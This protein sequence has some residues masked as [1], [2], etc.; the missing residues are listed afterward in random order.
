MSEDPHWVARTLAEF[1]SV[2]S[3]VYEAPERGFRPIDLDVPVFDDCSFT[4]LKKRRPLMPRLIA[5]GAS[6]SLILGLLGA[7][8]ASGQRAA[9]AAEWKPDAKAV[10]QLGPSVK[11]DSYTIRIPKGYELQETPPAPFGAK[12]WAWAGP[13]RAD[14]TKAQLLMNLLPIAPAQRE[15]AKRLTLEQL[16]EKRI[17]AIRGQRTDW[18][19]EKT[20]KD[21]INGLTFARIRWEGTEPKNQWDMRGF[22]YVARDGDTILYLSSQDLKAPGAQTLPLAD[23]AVLSFKK[24]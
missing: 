20:E 19:Q 18:K 1:V 9:P 12:F 5:L 13:A 24:N 6:F 3:P 7:H 16:A 23:A 11:L 17:A 22:V 4:R 15:Q 2:V 10:R 21:V 8:E 14:G